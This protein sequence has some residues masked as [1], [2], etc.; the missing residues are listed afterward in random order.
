MT[1]QMYGMVITGTSGG[2]ASRFTR[3]AKMVVIYYAMSTRSFAVA[4]GLAAEQEEPSAACR[5]HYSLAS[6]IPD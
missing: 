1:C 2:C 3:L 5:R 4:S 6:L